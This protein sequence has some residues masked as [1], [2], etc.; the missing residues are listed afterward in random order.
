MD[1]IYLLKSKGDAL[2]SFQSFVQSKVIPSGSLV[3]RLRVEK[4]GEY[5]SNEYKGCC[6]QTGVSLE[7][8]STNTPHQI[9]MSERVG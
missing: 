9:G 4:G 8:P 2:S 1:G 7:Y 3:E 6:L 5:I